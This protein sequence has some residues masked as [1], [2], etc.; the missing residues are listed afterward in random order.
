[1]IRKHPAPR[2][3]RGYDAS[4]RMRIS[5]RRRPRGFITPRECYVERPYGDGRL[6]AGWKSVATT[7]WDAESL[8][9][10]DLGR[11]ADEH[12]AIQ[13]VC[14]HQHKVDQEKKP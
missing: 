1:M 7:L 6:V 14:R 8:D 3:P 9:G 12:R 10:K 2:S 5:S 11:Y 4:G 13:A